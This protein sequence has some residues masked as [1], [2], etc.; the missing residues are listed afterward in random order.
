[1]WIGLILITA[2]NASANA[3]EQWRA[4]KEWRVQRSGT[5]IINIS[6]SSSSIKKKTEEVEKMAKRARKGIKTPGWES[7]WIIYLRLFP[8]ISSM[9]NTACHA[10]PPLFQVGS[11]ACFLLTA[12][13]LFL[14]FYCFPD[15]AKQTKERKPDCDSPRSGSCCISFF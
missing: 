5:D 13:L 9:P 1:M 14:F 8:R 11:S 12:G 3:G 4:E 10:T 7:S 2:G 15:L 6:H